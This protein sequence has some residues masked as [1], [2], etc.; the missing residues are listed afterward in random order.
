MVAS[1]VECQVEL[2]IRIE[3]RHIRDHQPRVLSRFFYL[4]PCLQYCEPG[5][6]YSGDLPA[7]LEERQY[8]RPCPASQV[9]GSTGWMIFY[10]VEQLWR[11]DAA[12]PGRP[13]QIPQVEIAA[14]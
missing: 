11:T 13:P 1:D 5:E 10:I 7:C 14:S 6:I 4:A 9:H 2:L 3:L 8:I 12:I